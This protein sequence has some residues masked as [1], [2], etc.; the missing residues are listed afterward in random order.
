MQK[1]CSIAMEH[2]QPFEIT[3]RKA[4]YITVFCLLLLIWPALHLGQYR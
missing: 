3:F 4:E 1:L 2:L